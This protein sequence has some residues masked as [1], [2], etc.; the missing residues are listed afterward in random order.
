M[1]FARRK[2]RDPDFFEGAAELLL[3]VALPIILI[4]GVV[5]I[6][7]SMLEALQWPSY[8]TSDYLRSMIRVMAWNVTAIIDRVAWALI[9]IVAC[10]AFAW[11]LRQRR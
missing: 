11:H 1:K 5:D 7:A 2:I 10:E 8:D 9:A 3:G 4:T 6:V